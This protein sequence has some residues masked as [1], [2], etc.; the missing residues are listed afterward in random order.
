MALRYV[1]RTDILGYPLS[2]INRCFLDF[3]ANT[4]FFQLVEFMSDEVVAAEPP[5]EEKI[6]IDKSQ[7]VSTAPKMSADEESDKK[8]K[9]KGKAKNIK[10]VPTVEKQSSSNSEAT[11]KDSK[12]S[13]ADKSDDSDPMSK[14]KRVPRKKAPKSVSKKPEESVSEE[15][16]AEAGEVDDSVKEGED[17]KI[18]NASK[19]RRERAK[20]KASQTTSSSTSKSLSAEGLAMLQDISAKAE[21]RRSKVNLT[22]PVL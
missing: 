17:K 22:I 19:Q 1:C 4:F 20:K 10:T 8:I 16:I 11:N 14:K 2:V 12:L 15:K 5:K 7:S 21:A 9:G 3:V 6:P 18:H 13:T